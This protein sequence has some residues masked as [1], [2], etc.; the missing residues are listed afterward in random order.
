MGVFPVQVGYKIKPLIF[1]SGGFPE[2]V[3]PGAPGRY[4]G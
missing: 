1:V 2:T 4:T 3:A